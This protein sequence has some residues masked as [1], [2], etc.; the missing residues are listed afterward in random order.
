MLNVPLIQYK[1]KGALLAAAIGDALGWQFE[2]NSFN[3][4]EKK[5]FRDNSFNMWIRRS[6]GRY[7]PHKETIYAGEYSDDTQLILSV[8]RSII[9]GDWLYFFRLKELPFWL[10]YERGGGRSL[11]LS[12]Q[13]YRMGEKPWLSKGR[14]RY[15]AAGGNGAAMRILP[16]IIYNRH[17][18]NIE[19]LMSDICMDSISTH[20]HPRAILGAACY[21]YVLK[22]L[23]DKTCKLEYGEIVSIVEEGVSIWG[24][25]YRE[26]VTD[27]WLES[28]H[29]SAGYSF[30]DVWDNTVNNMKEQ[31]SFIATSLKKGV[32]INDQ[33]VL[34][35]LGCF[36]REKGA[37]DIT[38]LAVIYFAS[39]YANNPIL[40]IK[41]AAFLSGIDTDTIAS[42]TGGILGM[43]HGVDWIPLEWRNVQDYNC[44]CD[45][46]E[47]LCSQN[48]KETSKKITS[49]RANELGKLI[50]SP[51]GKLKKIYSKTVFSG[52][53]G[54]ITITK[55]KSLLGQ[56][57]YCKRYERIPKENIYNNDVVDN[58][59]HKQTI[60][61]DTVSF[62]MV[63]LMRI[64]D[65][66]LFNR[67]SF[68]KI[69]RMIELLRGGENIAMISSTL[70]V[71]KGIILEINRCIKS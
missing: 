57:L 35:K 71:D 5:D 53:N 17:F 14:K 7:W 37:G 69:I 68:K 16:H 21:A 56:T 47:I 10:D 61:R 44:I 55:M 65:N 24:K 43:I 4:S 32:L 1:C 28:L 45:I 33:Y 60:L 38:V 42:M 54:K 62:S 11:K 8:A 40:G 18:D 51:I 59:T 2:V 58:R 41:S 67:I 20:G 52:K 39:K 31:L 27:D 6:G 19:A 48:V 29:S 30:N 63:D 70:K 22:M 23:M 25:F 3:I 34:S 46:A 26:A 64:K 15:F 66:P 50:E 13:M 49:I 9:S 36:G 12:A